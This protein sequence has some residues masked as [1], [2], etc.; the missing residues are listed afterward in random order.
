MTHLINIAADG[1][2]A[3][4]V[5]RD[6][7]VMIMAAADGIGFFSRTQGLFLRLPADG[8]TAERTA[9]LL[10]AA[11]IPQ[12]RFPVRW[13]DSQAGE[14][15]LSST[16]F[17]RADAVCYITTSVFVPPQGSE[18][19]E[20]C[21]MLLGVD[22]YGRLESS[23]V[24]RAED[25]AIR[26]AAR[27]ASPGMVEILPATA[28][29]RFYQPG[30]TLYN[31]ALIDRLYG[32]GAHQVQV[33]FSVSDRLD[34]SLPD[35][36]DQEISDAVFRD[37]ASATPVE[38]VKAFQAARRDAENTL[39][40][41]FAAAVAAGAPQ[42]REIEGPIYPFYIRPDTIAAVFAHDGPSLNILSRKAAGEPYNENSVLHFETPAAR[43][44]A[45]ARLTA[46][47]PAGP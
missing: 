7:I 42:L 35:V 32:D 28:R 2:P 15:K 14:D 18:T 38:Q 25:A 29:A 45:I 34:F 23:A 20:K 30:S 1:Q 19:A 21:A 47:R 27:A 26:A 46:P 5:D 11:G 22:G 37:Y 33:V 6:D 10:E 3:R 41:T 24:T 36:D 44:D 9:A 31:P 4:L 8:D 13:P 39:A 12:I 43:D 16:C 40:R 17:V